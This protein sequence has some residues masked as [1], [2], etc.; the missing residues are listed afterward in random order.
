[1]VYF[2]SVGTNEIGWQGGNNYIENLNLAL[3]ELEK[4][5]KIKLISSEKIRVSK[6]LR[7][8]PKFLI[9]DLKKTNSKGVSILF[10][11]WPHIKRVSKPVI[12][13]PDLQEIDLPEMFSKKERIER[14]IR[15]RLAIWKGSHFYF[16]SKT[17]EHRFRELYP[18]AKVLGSVRFSFN[19]QSMREIIS[20]EDFKNCRTCTEEGFFYSP[21]QFWKHKNHMNLLVAFT[22]YLNQGGKKHLILSGNLMEGTNNIF[23]E[24][25]VEFAKKIPEVHVYG[26]LP[27]GQQLSLF[28]SCK[29][30]IQP[31]LYEGWSSSIEEAIS[32]QKPIACSNIPVLIE[33]TLELPGVHLFDPMS[34]ESIASSMVSFERSNPLECEEII[35]DIRWWR[36]KADLMIIIKKY[37]S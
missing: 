5:N 12:W 35:S 3:S 8:R 25:A 15:R 9:Q 6:F 7:F 29:M 17:M 31:S 32:F 16:S 22:K 20:T 2:V 23:A 34:P 37:S 1:M 19:S 26:N 4:E 24:S 28:S 30:V 21:N 18:S 11:P 33:Q 36:F 14:R 13:I 10:L 27:R